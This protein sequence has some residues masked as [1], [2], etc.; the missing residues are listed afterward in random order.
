MFFLQQDE[1]ENRIKHFREDLLVKS[2]DE[3]IS[4]YYYNDFAPAAMD[5]DKYHKL[6]LLIKKKFNLSSIFN[7]IL[8]GSGRLGFSIKPTQEYR[9]FGEESDLDFAII[10]KS[11]N[12]AVP[13][14]SRRKK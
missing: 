3:I 11:K 4:K 5:I 2:D 13:F 1:I 7:V 8:I 10:S 12:K 6:R 9:L 14:I